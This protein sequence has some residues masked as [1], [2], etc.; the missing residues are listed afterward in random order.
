MPV[1]TIVFIFCLFSVFIEFLF[2]LVLFYATCTSYLFMLQ[3]NYK[4]S[5][6]IIEKITYFPPFQGG[7]MPFKVVSSHDDITANA[8]EWRIL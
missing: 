2:F 3:C 7:F 4:N 8:E 1:I 6:N 5:W